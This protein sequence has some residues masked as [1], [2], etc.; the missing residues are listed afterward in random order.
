MK[1]LVAFLL[2]AV[3]LSS[4]TSVYAWDRDDHH[5]REY[6]YDRGHWWLGDSILAGLAVGTIL[7]TLP[8]HYSTVYV[9]NVPYYYDG[10]YYYQRGSSGYVVVQPVAAPVVVAP[11]QTVVVAQPVGYNR[12]VTIQITNRNGT[13]TNVML[14]RKGNGFVGPQG[15]YYDTMPT[16]EQLS[17]IYSQ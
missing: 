1:K 15:E 6:H 8:P 16:T 2:V 11:A 14:V 9:G 5:S 7:A 13:V 3:I 12:S 4:F 17:A 10:T